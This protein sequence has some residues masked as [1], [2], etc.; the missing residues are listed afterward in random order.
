MTHNTIYSDNSEHARSKTI[1]K[2]I[3][4]MRYE[5]IHISG[6]A[7]SDAGARFAASAAQPGI[8][9]C[10]ADQHRNANSVTARGAPQA[11][12]DEIT[13]AGSALEG[14]ASKAHLGFAQR[15]L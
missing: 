15:Q 8:W 5:R 2:F 11:N 3:T 10:A 1:R 4:N 12:I 9:R 6:I 13:N 14:A 7:V